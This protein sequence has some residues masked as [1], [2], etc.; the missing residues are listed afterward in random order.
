MDRQGDATAVHLLVQE[1]CRDRIAR[2]GL[3]LRAQCPDMARGSALPL[4]VLEL[5]SSPRIRAPLL[6]P[7]LCSAKHYP[8]RAP[9]PTGATGTG[10]THERQP[11]RSQSGSCS[12]VMLC[13]AAIAGLHRYG[14]ASVLCF[15]FI[16][17]YP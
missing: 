8:G 4:V 2:S 15:S 14:L 1:C 11:H 3:V 6:L 16:A 13:T 7:V 12:C 10:G 5:G 17:F 9:D